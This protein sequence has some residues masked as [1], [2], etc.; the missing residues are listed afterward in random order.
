M[1]KEEI[2]KLFYIE[3]DYSRI[4]EL[5]KDSCEIW[6]FNILGKIELYSGNIIKAY[7]Y[8]NK[9]KSIFGCCYCNFLIGNIADTKK[10][11]SII[12]ESSP[13][14]NWLLCVIYIIENSYKE[15]P[16][17]FQ[18]R[19][20]Y[21]QDLNMLLLYNKKE[22]FNKLIEGN[23][24]LEYFN[25]EI[26]KYTGRVLLYNDDNQ[27]AKHFLTKSLDI[28]FRDS[29]THYLLGELY[30]KEGKIKQAEIEYELANEINNGYFPA[31]KKLKVLK[32]N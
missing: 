13:I 5:Q 12:K 9:A 31:I 19:N 3:K 25:K 18:I 16:T 11:L 28:F 21:E 29:E 17:Y 24:Y 10:I 26:Y 8:F 27:K 23:K 7:D 1:K 32:S 15:P 2:E 22:Y 14:V 30:E 20:F 6:S 4:K